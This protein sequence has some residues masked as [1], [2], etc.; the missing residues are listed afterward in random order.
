MSSYRIRLIGRGEKEKILS[1]MPVASF[2]QE[3]AEIHGACIKLFTDS[4][5]FNSLWKEN[6][7]AMPEYIRPHGR[8]FAVSKKY[9]KPG[10][11]LYEP[12]SSTAFIFGSDYYGQV[13]SVALAIVADLLEGSPSENRRYSIH[14]SFISKGKKNIEINLVILRCCC[15]P[16]F[17][18][19]A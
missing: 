19:Q 17:S 7:A 18:P 8:L 14:G 11:V 9:G 3:K 4:K 12:E 13:K 10:T 1:K 15:C 2:H 6:F 16:S 5:S